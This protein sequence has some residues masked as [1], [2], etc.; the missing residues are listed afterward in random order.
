MDC[1]VVLFLTFWGPS[2]LFS[3][4]PA[5]ICIP[6]SSTQGFSLSTSSLTLVISSLFDNSHLRDVRGY[7]TVV[8]ICISLMISNTEFYVLVCHVYVFEKMSIQICPFFHQIVSTLFL[9]FVS[10]WVVWVL[11]IFWMSVANISFHSA[12][13]LFTCWWFPL[14]CPAFWVWCNPTCWFLLLLLSILVSG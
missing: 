4:V 1:I 5:F 8:L 9:S 14:P 7:V 11:F 2:I 13:Y 12:G 6:V 3:I 10:C